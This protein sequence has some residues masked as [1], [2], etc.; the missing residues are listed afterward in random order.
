MVFS[1]GVI[2]SAA[3]LTVLFV[4]VCCD[5][6]CVLGFVVMLHD[7]PHK[8]NKSKHRKC[9][10]HLRSMVD[11]H[12][13]DS[14][15]LDISVTLVVV[16]FHLQLIELNTV[17]WSVNCHVHHFL[18]LWFSAWL[19]YSVLFNLAP[20]VNGLFSAWDI[21]ASVWTKKHVF[22]LV[23]NDLGLRHPCI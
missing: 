15:V 4:L 8:V 5:S 19:C 13:R 18:F 22:A 7:E 1:V 12:Q 10:K 2:P 16:A 23:L 9:L 17:V 11:V 20:E 21:L 6:G 3:G 14:T